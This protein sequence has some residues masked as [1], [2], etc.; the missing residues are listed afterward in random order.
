[1]S[2]KLNSSPAI[3]F[4][5]QL[6]VKQFKPNLKNGFVTNPDRKN[7]EDPGQAVGRPK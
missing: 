7:A 3:S 5:G 4:V 6:S 2:V 1:L